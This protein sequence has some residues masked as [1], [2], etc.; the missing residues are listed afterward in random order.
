MKNI[1]SDQ[2]F[3]FLFGKGGYVLVALVDLSDCLPACLSVCKQ[4][5]LNMYQWIAMK[6]YGGSRVVQGRTGQIL[7]AIWILDE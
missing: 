2:T 7:V 1:L 4:H 3:Y 5:Y 6:C